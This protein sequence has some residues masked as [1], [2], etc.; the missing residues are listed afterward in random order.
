[1]RRTLKISGSKPPAAVVAGP[2]IKRKPII[3]ITAATPIIIKLILSSAKFLGISFVSLTVL[4]LSDN[5][6]A[7]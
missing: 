2:V 1:M 3:I 4:F 6:K 5:F 7:Q